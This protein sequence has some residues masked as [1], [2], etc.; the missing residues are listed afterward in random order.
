MVAPVAILVKSL[1]ITGLVQ[2]IS[3]FIVD[4][5]GGVSVAL[6]LMIF[7]ISIL[8][9]MA[10]P[11]VVVYILVGSVALPAM[12]TA[13]IDKLAAHFALFYFSVLGELTPPVGPACMVTAGIA[14][15]SY[16]KTCKQAII[17]GFPVFVM[18]FIFFTWPRILNLGSIDCL[19]AFGL[20]LTGLTA[21]TMGLWIPA[22]KKI[23]YVLRFILVFL[24]CAILFF[25][26]GVFLYASLGVTIVIIALVWRSYFFPREPEM[27]ME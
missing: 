6:F 27:L 21:I 9:G 22:G 3:Y 10:C 8:F 7:L 1:M 19:I 2:K 4:W 11:P 26:S 20:C 16:L 18:P 24:G 14:G 17:L 13:G 23:V 5:S 15:A 12:H 25:A